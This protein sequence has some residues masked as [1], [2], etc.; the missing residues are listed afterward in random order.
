MN[1]SPYMPTTYD[2]SNKFQK[3]LTISLDN[4]DDDSIIK[5]L[6]WLSVVF[7]SEFDPAE[8]GERAGRRV[9]FPKVRD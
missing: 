6:M 2:D 8:S 1:I 3:R 4:A 7:V 5:V 9:S